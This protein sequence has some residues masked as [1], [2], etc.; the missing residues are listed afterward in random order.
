LP[1]RIGER[2]SLSYLFCSKGVGMVAYFWGV[3]SS[4]PVTSELYGCVLTHLGKPSFW[5]RYLVTVPGTSE[6]LTTEEITLLHN[7]GLKILPIYNKLTSTTGYQNGSVAA[8]NAIFYARR[9]KVPHGVAI[10]SNIERFNDIDAAWIR[11][12]F[13]A[14]Y[15]SPYLAGFY[16]DSKRGNFMEA[17]CQA[18]SAENKLKTHSVLWGAQPETGVTKANNAPTFHPVSPSCGG[19]VWGWQYGR[20]ATNCPVNT[21]LVT[22]QL[23]SKLW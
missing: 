3:D 2:P 5:G 21:N 23:F 19:N 18:T 20:D 12:W 9:L 22:S 13:D 7:S 1:L 15:K 4:T 8:Q 6:G 14:L 17:I 16:F 10:F 11:G